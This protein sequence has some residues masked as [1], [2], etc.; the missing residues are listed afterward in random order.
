M[1]SPFP[2]MNPYLEHP[3]AWSD[4]HERYVIT[5][6][7]ELGRAIP[8]KYFVKVDQNVYGQD[9]GGELALIGRGDAYVVASG[10]SPRTE[11]NRSS[12]AL[13]PASGT[14][15]FT[16]QLSLE[17][18]FLEIR[19]SQS[20]KVITVIELLSPTNKRTGEKRNQF[21]TKRR[22][23]VAS[24]TNYVELDLLRGFP[25]LPLRELGACDY[26]ALV[27]RASARPKADIWSISLRDELPVIPIPLRDE[28]EFTSLALQPSLHEVYDDG[29]YDRYIYEH[30]LQP[31][32]PTEDEAWART[33]AGLA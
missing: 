33:V 16:E 11:S 29:T 22:A 24:D 5:L 8:R 17:E 7:R 15:T 2:G 4:F 28:N 18:S 13:T 9:T 21:L 10:N 1:P 3:D 12:A 31:P 30:E 25:R 26:Y 32:L 6:A 14:V 19:D 27:S 23:I 20:R